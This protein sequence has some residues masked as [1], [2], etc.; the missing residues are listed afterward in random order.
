MIFA[1]IY[2][3]HSWHLYAVEGR[4]GFNSGID[5]ESDLIPS[6]IPEIGMGMGINFQR[7]GFELELLKN[8]WN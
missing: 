1:R 4:P 8:R 7:I 2:T 3:H 6:L 5:L